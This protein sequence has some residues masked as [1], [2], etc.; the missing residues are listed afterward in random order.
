MLSENS[1]TVEEEE[2][3]MGNQ[4]IFCQKNILYRGKIEGKGSE[5]GKNSTC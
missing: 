2:N 3:T 5:E 4:L 1:V